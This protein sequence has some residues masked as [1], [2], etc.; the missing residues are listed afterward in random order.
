MCGTVDAVSDT[1]RHA[2]DVLTDTWHNVSAPVVD[3]PLGR[4]ATNITTGGLSAPAFA[5]YD[6]SR[7]KDLGSSI[8]N[9]AAGYYG[10]ESMGNSTGLSDWMSGG[11]SALS[12]PPGADPTAFTGSPTDLQLPPG[13]SPE[14]GWDVAPE[15]LGSSG[16]SVMGTNPVDYS[17]G[18]Q[19]GRLG[20]GTTD[21]G[22]PTGL[23]MVSQGQMSPMPEV[24]QGAP[25]SYNP[26]ANQTPGDMSLMDYVRQGDRW[27]RENLGMGAGRLGKGLY[28]MYRKNQAADLLQQQQQHAMQHWQQNE[29][30]INKYY[31]A[32]SPEALALEQQLA[33]QDAKAGRN[34]QYGQRAVDLAAKMA[35]R[36][37]QFRTGMTPNQNALL[38]GASQLG[39]RAQGERTDMFSPLAQQWT[40]SQLGW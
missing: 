2:G 12:V 19:F 30:Q 26:A 6:V 23:E 13:A 8:V 40:L 37:A 32:G 22:Q 18:G 38:G 28:D 17:N 1:V 4:M 34:S 29:D 5:A 7:G 10:G 31:A 25:L 9:G 11:G 36:R 27:S 24:G 35:E 21:L 14:P 3:T 16:S 15:S 33:R 39:Q 20:T